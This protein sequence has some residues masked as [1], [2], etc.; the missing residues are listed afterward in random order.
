MW[1]QHGEDSNSWSSHWKR[2]STNGSQQS[3]SSQEI[4]NFHQNKRSE[5][6]S[7][8]HKFL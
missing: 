6:L 3:Q 2:T 1:F 7:D 4:E 5:K 8:I